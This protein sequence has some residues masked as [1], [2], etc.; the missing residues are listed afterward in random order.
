MSQT[1]VVKLGGSIVAP[2][3]EL[4]FDF[5]YLDKLRAVISPNLENGDKFFF[6]L[7]GGA[8]ARNYRDL[9]K[10]AGLTDTMQLHWIGT[11]VNV[12]HAEIVRAYWNDIADDGIYKYEDYYTDQPLE[13]VKSVKVGGGGRPGHS[14]DV[15]TVRVAIK[16]GA[17]TIISLKNIDGVYSADPTTHPEATRCDKLTWKEYLDIIGNPQEHAPGANFPIDP[18]AAKDAQS[19]GLQFI[20]VKGWDLPNLTNLLSGKPYIGTIVSDN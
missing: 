18:I 6:V 1:Y 5:S 4:L 10:A 3:E 19:N 11:T 16:T 20:V 12:L 15:D 7:G 17:K 2:S 8:T 9:A 13:I 14:G